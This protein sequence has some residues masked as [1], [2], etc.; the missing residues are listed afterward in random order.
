MNSC[1]KEHTCYCVETDHNVVLDSTNV[2]VR[3]TD[4]RARI[5]CDQY[6]DVWKTSL[7]PEAVTD[8]EIR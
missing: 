7:I 1:Q 4:R 6:E 2:T 8:C 5:S 3:G